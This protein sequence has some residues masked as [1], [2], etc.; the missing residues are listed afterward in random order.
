[1]LPDT[2]SLYVHVP[3]CTLKCDY[4]DF[5]SCTGTP[6]EKQ[7]HIIRETLFQAEYLLQQMGNPQIETLF[8]GGGTPNSLPDSTLETLLTGLKRLSGGKYFEYTCEA[9]PESITPGNLKL[10]WDGG[11]TRLSLCIQSFNSRLLTFLR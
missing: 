5:F 9:N 1:M 3:F 10:L 6:V 8:I 2:L 4:C 7:N 11:V